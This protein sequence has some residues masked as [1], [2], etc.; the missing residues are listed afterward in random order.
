[1]TPQFK[2]PPWAFF[3]GFTLIVFIMPGANYWT[4]NLNQTVPRFVSI[5]C[6]I[7]GGLYLLF[8]LAR[9]VHRF[10]DEIDKDRIANKRRRDEN[11]IFQKTS[12]LE[13]DRKTFKLSAEKNQWR[14]G[15]PDLDLPKKVIR[16]SDF[17]KKKNRKNN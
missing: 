4:T 7:I 2:R 8:R 12:L 5:P 6:S 1:M 11:F 14:K 13:L 3:E 16:K 15:N 9:Y 10:I 17:Q